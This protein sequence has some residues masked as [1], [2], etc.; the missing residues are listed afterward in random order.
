MLVYW[1]GMSQPPK[2]TI[3]APCAACQSWSGVRITPAFR[4]EGVLVLI[5]YGSREEG[6]SAN[7]FVSGPKRGFFMCDEWMRGLQLVMTL[8]QF[9]TL[10]RNSAFKYEYLGGTAYIT[11]R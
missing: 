3:R 1:M 11:P 10:P 5:W 8:D 2:S 9:H 7:R 4:S 6:A